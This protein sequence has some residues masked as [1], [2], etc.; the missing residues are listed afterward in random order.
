MIFPFQICRTHNL[1]FSLRNT[2]MITN[3]LSGSYII[4]NKIDFSLKL[5][6]HIDQVEILD[7]N[8]L[9]NQGYLVQTEIENNETEDY[10]INYS[11][12]T[13]DVGLNWW[14]STGS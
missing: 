10:N 11:T 1:L 7:F 13:A 5:R 3:V 14:F 8:R 2:C 4:S 6:Y 9:D 12:W